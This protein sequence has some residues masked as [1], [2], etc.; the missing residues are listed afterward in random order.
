[1][2]TK[3]DGSMALMVTGPLDY[4]TAQMYEVVITCS[5]GQFNISKVTMSSHRLSKVYHPVFSS[6]KSFKSSNF[7]SHQKQQVVYIVVDI[8]WD[9]GLLAFLPVQYCC[10]C[11]L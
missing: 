2:D 1:V 5:D 8:L 3:A 9:M 6:G 11:A 4:E 10:Y 7:T